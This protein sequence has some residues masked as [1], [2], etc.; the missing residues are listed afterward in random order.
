MKR[1]KC[2]QQVKDLITIEEDMIDLAQKTKFRK[3]KF[4]VKRKLN[5]NLKI[6]K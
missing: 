2:P 4:N 1:N 5:K 3:A 6:I